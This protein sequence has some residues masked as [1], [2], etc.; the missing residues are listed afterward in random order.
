[1]KVTGTWTLNKT[2]NQ[3][4]RVFVH[5]PDTGAQ[6]QQAHYQISGLTG[7]TRD[8]YL[9]QHYKA[10]TWVPLGAYQFNGTP[11]V[12]L[13][14][15]TADGTADDD[16]AW[17]AVAFQPLPGKPK[18]MIVAMGDSYAS[19][20]GAG[21]YSPESDTNHG[22][23]QWNGCRRSAN[24]WARKVILPFNSTPTGELA[25]KY[26]ASMDFQNV[27]CSGARTSQL[28]PGDPISWGF[29]GN[30]HEK[31][32]IDSGVLS[33]DTTLVMLTIGGNDSNNFTNAVTNCY[34]VG[35]CNQNDYTGK[36]D[37]AVA[38]TG[39]LIGD[40]H[41]AAPNAQIVLMSYP[42][43]VADQPCLTANFDALNYLADYM[44]DK[45]KAKVDE[46]KQTGI[47]VAFADAIPAFHGHGLCDSDEYIN[48]IVAGPNGDGDYH[49]GDPANPVPCIPV[50]GVC[51]S[52]ESFHPKSSGTST[53]AQVMDQKLA[54]I[55]Y[56]GG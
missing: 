42:H 20:E 5:L 46:L 12:S 52:L 7:G 54:D 38:D 17:D 22:T 56:T 3:W 32:Q 31:S 2:L 30:Y 19:G 23:P 6:T 36:I 4:A 34:I 9:N 41:T 11:T 49:K 53:Y 29:M 25:D 18:H 28:M 15:E 50:S 27:T 37:T 47:K 35:V 16:V 40:I 48:G 13:S 55:G 14:N 45:Q 51:V 1:M 24:S 43:I 10:N 26:D 33:A 39:T 8:R 21:A 44:R